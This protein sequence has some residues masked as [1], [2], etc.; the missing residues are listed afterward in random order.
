MSGSDETW[1]NALSESCCLGL[2]SYLLLP[3]FFCGAQFG[4]SEPN[5]VPLFS[6][7]LHLVSLSLS[8]PFF[9]Y[10]FLKKQTTNI[11]R[12]LIRDWLSSISA[13][14][15][16]LLGHHLADAIDLGGRLFDANSSDVN[17]SFR[18]C[19]QCPVETLSDVPSHFMFI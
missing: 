9:S 18:D 3:V 2:S 1:Q 17:S 15:M 5:A 11:L 19:P 10:F 7:S 13:E 4:R 6:P 12:L 8:F 14:R 16:L